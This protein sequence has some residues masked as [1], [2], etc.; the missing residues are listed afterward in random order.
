MKKTILMFAAVSMIY[1]TVA[2]QESA[3]TN[4][5][6]DYS[7]WSLAIKGGVNHYRIQRDDR[8]TLSRPGDNGIQYFI[9]KS[10]W[11]VPVIQVEYTATPYYGIGLEAGY[12]NY[13]R[14][15]FEGHTIDAILNSSVN[16]SNLVSPLRRG[17]WHKTALY[18][19]FGLGYGF[20][21]YKDRDPL[22]NTEDSHSSAIA[23]GG[24]N[25]DVNFSRSLALILEGQYRAYDFDILGGK[26]GADGSQGTYNNDAWLVNI[27]LRFKFGAVNN[28]HT[29]NA[30]V[31]EYFA[32]LY[33]VAPQD[34]GLKQRVDALENG[35][36]NL[37]GDLKKLEPK[38]NKNTNDI[39]QL[40]RD[41]QKLNGAVNDL[42]KPTTVT[43]SFDNIHFHFDKS[44]IANDNPLD[45]PNSFEVLNNIATILKENAMGNKIRII[46]HTDAIGTDAYNQALSLDRAVSVKNYLVSKGIPANDITVAGMGEKQ[47]VATNDTADGRAKNRRVEFEISK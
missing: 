45:K 3:G 6:T 39:D 43:A 24:F 26:H 33:Q 31:K 29:R 42:N 22:V 37:D 35:L 28:V 11:Q 23:A 13:N 17:F 12:Y 36:K 32:D 21:S 2:A 4:A 18:V 47:P 16:L 44:T 1:G 46:G 41:L 9:L 27:G 15:Q 30:T 38:V 10:S 7:R 25:F 34:D 5:V 40:K 20:N 8:A 14:Y 19:N